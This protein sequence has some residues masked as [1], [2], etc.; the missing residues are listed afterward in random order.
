MLAPDIRATSQS[1]GYG[2]SKSGVASSFS[3]KPGTSL[4]VN[5]TASSPG[6]Y[7]IGT[8]GSN[9]RGNANATPRCRRADR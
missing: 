4:E 3:R 6:I 2:S 5:Q 9:D 1:H 8:D 7:E